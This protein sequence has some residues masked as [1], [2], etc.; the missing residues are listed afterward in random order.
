MGNAQQSTTI[1]P[2]ALDRFTLSFEYDRTIQEIRR[3]VRHRTM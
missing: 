1:Q 2:S 3:D